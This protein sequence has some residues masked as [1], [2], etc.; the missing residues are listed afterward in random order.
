LLQIIYVR[1]RRIYISLNKYRKEEPGVL[2][3][4]EVKP[5]LIDFED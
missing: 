1:E 3:R 4:E 2:H 5:D